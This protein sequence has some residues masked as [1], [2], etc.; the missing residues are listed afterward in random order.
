MKQTQT[1]AATEWVATMTFSDR[2]TE[3][4][5]KEG[6][7]YTAPEYRGRHSV[8]AVSA[9]TSRANTRP[10]ARAAGSGSQRPRR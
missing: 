8:T 6:G 7:I 4:L 3:A 1:K 5:Y 9:T 10:H 2:G